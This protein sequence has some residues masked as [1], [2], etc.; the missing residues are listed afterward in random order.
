MTYSDSDAQAVK[1]YYSD[2]LATM[3][4][5]AG[6][7]GISNT[8]G[9]EHKMAILQDWAL[10]N[11]LTVA[12]AR[13]A[14]LQYWVQAEEL[15][16]TDSIEVLTFAVEYLSNEVHQQAIAKNPHATAEILEQV[17]NQG[18]VKTMAVVA[19]N[20]NATDAM[21]AGLL[22]TANKVMRCLAGGIRNAWPEKTHSDH[23][24]DRA[25]EL[26]NA[27]LRAQESRKAKGAA[28]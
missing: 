8:A 20:P 28:E 17:I 22:E 10:S 5:E 3:L 15:E 18:T 14:D 27:V 11:H 24:A 16:I 9:T 4:A 12:Q 23:Q 7:C 6:R 19:A 13:F 26:R 1:D 25:D 21:L 2:R